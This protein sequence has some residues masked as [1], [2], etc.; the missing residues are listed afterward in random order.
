M[1]SA[2]RSAS[3]LMISPTSDWTAAE[4]FSGY[5]ARTSPSRD[6]D[7]ASVRIEIS[8]SSSVRAGSSG[9][10]PRARRVALEASS[11]AS[12]SCRVSMYESLIEA[13]SPAIPALKSSRLAAR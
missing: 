10:A 7:R 2:L 12:S 11:R 9:C 13:I 3:T 1:V 6:E 4:G 8:S 5:L